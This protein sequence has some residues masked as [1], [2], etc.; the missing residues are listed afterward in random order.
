M[1]DS[2]IKSLI[3]L[4]VLVFAQ[5]CGAKDEGPVTALVKGTVKI[6][7]APIV[8]GDIIFEPADGQGPAAAGV[9][10]E[11]QFEFESPVGT[12]KVMIYASRKS[13]KKGS[14]FG[15]D[16]M[17]SYIPEKYNAKS[18]LEKTIVPGS[19]NEFQFALQSKSSG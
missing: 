7:G 18:V 16:L 4:C 5:G 9:I 13:G 1:L 2:V 14:D 17:E 12:K 8:K 15:E 10:T 3:M 11:G 19:E 6:D